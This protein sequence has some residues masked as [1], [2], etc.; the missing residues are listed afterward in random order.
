M[1][2]S[3]TTP[4]NINPLWSEKINTYALTSAPPPQGHSSAL[5][6]SVLYSLVIQLDQ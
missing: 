3:E 1:R 2:D 5:R 4:P 6:V